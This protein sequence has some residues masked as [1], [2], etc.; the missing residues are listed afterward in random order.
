MT[1]TGP[2]GDGLEPVRAA[3]P[4]KREE[5]IARIQL[6]QSYLPTSKGAMPSQKQMDAA[7]LTAEQRQNLARIEAAQNYLPGGSGHVS[8]EQMRAA[9]L[10]ETQQ[11][12]LARMEAAQNY[13]PGGSGHVSAEQMRAAGLSET[14]QQ[15]LAR[16]ELAQQYL[17]QTTTQENFVTQWQSTASGAQMAQLEHL[18][19]Q[20]RPAEFH[21]FEGGGETESSAPEIGPINLTFNVTIQ[22]NA[23]R[24][25]VQA[26]VQQSI[27]LIRESFEDQLRRYQHENRRRS[28]TW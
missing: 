19:A 15:S 14:Q 7:G 28:M 23:D 12:S 26:G 17:P 8:E 2:D 25:E 5:K 16:M 6:A 18:E 22:G 21:G 20:S 1:A 3:A 9:G 11:Q 13:L 27:P 24:N 10:S 4:L